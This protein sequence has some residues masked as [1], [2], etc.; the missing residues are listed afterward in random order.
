[1]GRNLNG[2]VLYSLKS[3]DRYRLIGELTYLLAFSDLHRKYLINDIGV[4]FFPPIDLNQFRIYKV[5][6]DPVAFVTWAYLTK[7]CEGRYLSGEYSLAFDDWKA[8]DRG[9]VMDFLAPFG[10]A[11]SVLS[12]LKTNV[13]ANQVGRAVRV[14]SNGKIKK[15]YKLHGANVAKKFK[16]N[17]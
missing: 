14:D 5:N 15:I 4:M 2:G 11:K 9:W 16:S 3:I 1:M 13:F 10:H 6:D 8:G 17:L 12:D 7:E